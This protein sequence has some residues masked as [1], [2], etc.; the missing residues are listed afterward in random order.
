[1]ARD[2]VAV[3][4]NLAGAVASFVAGTPMNVTKVCAELGVTPKTFYKYVN[5]F[6]IDGVEGFFP[7][8]RRPV[9]S[10]GRLDAALEDVIVAGRKELQGSGWDYGADAI[11]MWLQDHVDQW[12]S[13]LVVPSRSTIN[14][15]L[16]ARGHLTKMPQRRPKRVSRRFEYSTVN[17]L[18]QMD[19]FEVK[20]T[21]GAVVVVIHVNDDC[22][23][24]D[25][26][27]WAVRTENGPDAWSTFCVAVNEN[28]LPA[29][30]LTD[31][32]GAFSGKRRGWTTQLEK[33]TA[34]LG[35]QQIASSP[36]H[37]QTCGKNERAH[38]RVRKWL[39]NQPTPST[40]AELQDLLDRYRAGYNARRNR[41]LG[42]LTPDQRFALGPVSYPAE[43]LPAIAHV[44]RHLV[45][46]TGGIGVDDTLIG[47]GRRHAH[48]TATVFR[49]GDH[50]TVF[51]N[52]VLVRELLIDRTRHYQPQNA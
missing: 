43:S 14:R 36:G 52:D 18:W 51:V 26:A 8:S 15:V 27:L 21:T 13:P 10:T 50:V 42:G 5:R 47:I 49:T 9:T 45:T 19:G 7:R 12:P 2:G 1:M 40:L 3:G 17:A 28:G 48:Q 33:N 30:L 25:L 44:T 24:K 34:A 39:R 38:Q 20:L 11:V 22:S 41:V 37:P 29:R 16:D 46:T 23:R 4:Q 32:G 35:I 6:R 31:N